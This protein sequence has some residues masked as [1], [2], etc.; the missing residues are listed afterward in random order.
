MTVEAHS[1]EWA[2]YPVQDCGDINVVPTNDVISHVLCRCCECDPVSD[3][4]VVIHSVFY[5]SMWTGELWA[6]PLS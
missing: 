1:T 5:G 4:R 2:V 3:G 6:T